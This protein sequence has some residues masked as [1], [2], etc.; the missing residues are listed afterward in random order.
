MVKTVSTGGEAD[1]VPIR[2]P[3]YKA[4]VTVDN[5]KMRA[6]LDHGAQVSIVR[7]GLLPKVRETQGWTK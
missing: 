6:L 3:T 2:G 4:E 7:R 1:E 5:V